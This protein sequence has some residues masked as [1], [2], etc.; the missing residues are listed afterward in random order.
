MSIRREEK[1]EENEKKKTKS[2]KVDYIRMH[3]IAEGVK[4]VKKN[5][6]LQV[7]IL[8]LSTRNNNNYCKIIHI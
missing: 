2:S 4:I 8:N 6:N 5:G 7:N 3:D 1:W